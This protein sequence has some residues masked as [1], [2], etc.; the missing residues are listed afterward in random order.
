MKRWI[1]S[2]KETLEFD[3]EGNAVPPEIA[4]AL[5]NSKVRNRKGQLIACYHG[6]NAEFNQFKEEFISQSSGNIGWFGKGFYFTDNIKLASSYGSILKRCYLNITNPF[7]YSSE[8][9]IYTLFSLG[10]EPRIYD[11]R[12]QPYAYLDNEEPI[13]IFTKAVKEAGFD[14]VK[15]SYRQAKYRSQTRGASNATEYVCFRPDQVHF[16]HAEEA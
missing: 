3:N 14:G 4:A 9:S 2:A 16:L 5:R 7:V 10:V 1:R 13:E 15:F 12:L 6:T 11:G 8:D